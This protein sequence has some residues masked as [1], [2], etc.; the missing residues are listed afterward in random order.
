VLGESEDRVVGIENRELHEQERL[1]R[2]SD[3]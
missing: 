1:G 3:G 2:T